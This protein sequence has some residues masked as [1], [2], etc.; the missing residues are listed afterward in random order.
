MKK[1]LLF[2]SVFIMITV[3]AQTERE[4]AINELN[5]FGEL[6]VSISIDD[7]AQA[8]D[9]VYNMSVVAKTKNSV[10]AYM[11]KSEFEQFLNMGLSYTVI[12]RANNKSSTVVSTVEEM[13][14]WDAYPSYD[15][16][17]QM[18]YQFQTDYPE[19]CKVENIGN[20]ND[21]REI[22][23]AKISDNVNEEEDEPE[24][25]YTAQMHGNEIMT[26]VL[27]LRFIDYFLSNYGTNAEITELV[28]NIE[29]YINPLAN[30]DGTYAGGNTNVSNSTRSN[31]DGKDL[32]RGFPYADSGE[33]YYSTEPHEVGLFKTFAQNHHFVMSANIHTGYEVVNYP[34]DIWTT[35]DPY[36]FGYPIRPHADNDWWIYASRIYA[37]KA[38]VD[39]ASQ[40]LNSYLDDQDNG[41]TEGGDWSVINGSRMDYIT[42]YTNCR[43]TTFELQD[44][45]GSNGFILDASELPKYWLANKQ[46]LID[47]MKEVLYGFRGVVTDEITGSPIVAKVEIVGHDTDN[48]HVYS[49]LPVGNY[50]RPIY[51]GSYEVTFSADGYQSKTLQ[52]SVLN[53]D[54]TIE[55]VTLLP[56]NI[57]VSEHDSKNSVNVYPVPSS[58]IVNIE[59]IVEYSNLKIL[60]VKGSVVYNNKKII[61]NSVELN[62]SNLDKGVY[63]IE[64]SS[65]KTIIRKKL[66]L[67]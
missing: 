42:Y 45:Y 53:N 33:E 35:N 13:S 43:E 27:M 44:T 20:S 57:S 64:L 48:S 58:G 21:G 5:E 9:F 37:D 16:F 22:L 61:N 56:L 59:N 18:M 66:I 1:I 4:V 12:Q 47:Y 11:N 67:E 8:K 62:L 52:I 25:L 60:S 24:F 17:V 23:V 6:L 19:L 38:Q 2:I 54:I 32:N 14:D 40:G 39:G 55:N 65:N 41:I 15:L 3:N 34:W 26:Y 7:Q 50:H 36:G 10:L 30:P 29:I 63:T 28:D 51:E 46:A 49:A 31:A